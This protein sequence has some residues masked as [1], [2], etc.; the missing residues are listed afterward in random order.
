MTFATCEALQGRKH[1]VVPFANDNGE[2]SHSIQ[3]YIELGLWAHIAEGGKVVTIDDQRLA[4]IRAR[5]LSR[6]AA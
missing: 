6:P 5:E 1:R 4:K 2:P 3:A